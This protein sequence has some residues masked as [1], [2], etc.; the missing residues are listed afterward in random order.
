MSSEEAM[1]VVWWMDADV[2]SSCEHRSVVPCG[3]A[4]DSP[5]NHW[6]ESLPGSI[7][8]FEGCDVATN[9]CL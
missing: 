7:V 8:D 5:A 9:F 6:R 1:V 3:F 4:G 2:G